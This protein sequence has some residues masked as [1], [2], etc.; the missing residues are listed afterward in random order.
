M[1][2]YQSSGE[3]GA[4]SGNESGGEA[5]TKEEEPREMTLDEYKA[6]QQQSRVK[7]EFKVRKAGEGVNDEQWKKTYVL[8]KKE[9]SEDEVEE[10]DD[11]EEEEEHH[12][13]S[14]IVLNIDFQFTDSPM[15]GGRGR[16]RGRGGVG[17]RGGRGGMSGRGGRG[18]P[19]GGG[20]GGY[21]GG[22][23]RGARAA[24]RPAAPK[25]DDEGDFPSL[26]GA[27]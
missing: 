16:G 15:R 24:P 19:V 3:D 17:G 25:M 14:K 27:K 9:V 4:A 20:G 2:C 21:G 26:K 13:K 12:G 23:N 7:P 11:E 5:G 10:S 1:Q 6:M 8:K 18:G 22:Y